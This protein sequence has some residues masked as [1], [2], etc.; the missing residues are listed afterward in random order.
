MFGDD[1][2]KSLLSAGF[3][4]GGTIT[5]ELIAKLNATSLIRP[6]Q[7]LQAG[8]TLNECLLAEVLAIEVQQIKP[9]Q[10]DAGGPLSQG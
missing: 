1:A 8:S 4:Q 9:I 2:L 10:D 7:T 3:E 5:I 6:N